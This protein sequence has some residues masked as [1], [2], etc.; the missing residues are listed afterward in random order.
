MLERNVQVRVFVSSTFRD[1]HAERDYLNRIVFPEVQ[2]R[3][4]RVG[5]DFTG[6]DLRWGITEEE[7]QHGKV[8][9]R[10]LALVDHCAP[11]FLGLVGSRY[12]WVTAAEP[13]TRRELS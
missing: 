7:A 12:G 3:C 4:A 8:L 2:H 13:N 5:L 6:I 9:E 1:M 11:F 10:S